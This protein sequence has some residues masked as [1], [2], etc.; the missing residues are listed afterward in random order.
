[1][2]HLHRPKD[3]SCIPDETEP[4]DELVTHANERTNYELIE[5]VYQPNE[6]KEC[7]LISTLFSDCEEGKSEQEETPKE[8]QLEQAGSE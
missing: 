6:C 8:N 3:D 7:W 2:R 5:H 4:E 1:M